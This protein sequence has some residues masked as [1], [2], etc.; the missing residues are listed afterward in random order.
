MA[1]WDDTKKTDNTAAATHEANKS[2]CQGDPVWERLF[3]LRRL[4][5]AQGALG[6]LEQNAAIERD[7]LLTEIHNI[8]RALAAL[9]GPPMLV[10]TQRE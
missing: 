8:Q 9:D 7:R 4:R 3:L 5:D 10:I 6:S 2:R 1:T